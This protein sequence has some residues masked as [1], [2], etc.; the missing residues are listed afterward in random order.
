MNYNTVSL[1]PLTLGIIIYVRGRVGI[2]GAV[3]STSFV[4]SE[5]I[6]NVIDVIRKF[7]SASFR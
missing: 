2:A 5:M 1:D 4:R 3:L 7:Q 6:P